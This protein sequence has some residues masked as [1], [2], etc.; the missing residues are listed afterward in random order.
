MAGKGD[1]EG[2]AR[3]VGGKQELQKP[4]EK[5]VVRVS[6]IAQCCSCETEHKIVYQ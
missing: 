1:R 2:V 4:M 5:S 3:D 6:G